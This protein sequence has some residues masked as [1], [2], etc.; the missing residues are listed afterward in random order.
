MKRSSF[1]KSSTKENTEPKNANSSQALLIA[2]EG[3]ADEPI[4]E[5]AGIGPHGIAYMRQRFVEEEFEVSLE[6]KAQRHRHG[7]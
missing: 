1:V 4:A 7:H 6:G 2:N 3:Y 5:R